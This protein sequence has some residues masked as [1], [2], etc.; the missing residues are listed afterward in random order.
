VKAGRLFGM[1]E[2][3]DPNADVFISLEGTEIPLS[4]ARYEP[5]PHPR[6]ILVPDRLKLLMF[7]EKLKI[8]VER[9]H[10]GHPPE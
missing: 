6:V 7:L 8:E 1:F 10:L 5:G 3:R 4:G 9:G 2:N